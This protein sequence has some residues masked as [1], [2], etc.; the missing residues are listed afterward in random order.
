MK[1]KTLTTQPKTDLD[2]KKRTYYHLV[3]DKSGSMESCWNEAKQVINQQLQDLKRIQVENLDS[4]ILFS[5]CAFNQALKFSNELMNVET[6]QVDWYAIYPDGMTSLYD[7][8]G[9]SIGFI[10]KKAGEG[11]ESKDSDVVMLILTDGYENASKKYTGLDIK[12]MIQASEQTEKWN[13]LFLGAGLDIAEV[14]NKLGLMNNN[15]IS[16]AKDHISKAFARV[17]DDL[18]GFV[19]SK[20]E[21]QKKR[22]FFQKGQGRN[23]FPF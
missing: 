9:E 20:S 15:S 5:F 12:E 3:L 16:F 13:F 18:E 23:D 14:T 2:M 8:I 21:D 4:E 6:A 19:K 11:L 7:A 10:K 1:N 22:G 17:S